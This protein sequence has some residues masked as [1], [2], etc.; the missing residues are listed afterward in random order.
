MKFN[1]E[2][3]SE[4]FN[5]IKNIFLK[6]PK[7][8]IFILFVIVFGLIYFNNNSNTVKV[9]YLETG[10]LK[11]IVS[12]SGI[13]TPSQES[14]LAFE[15]SGRIQSI[16][17]KV[18]DSVKTGQ[19]LSNLSSGV[20]YA[21]V[22]NAQAQLGSAQANLQDALNGPSLT[23]I[24]VKQSTV[25]S[26]LITLYSDYNSSLDTI[27]I[28]NSSLT[29][30]LGNKIS[31]IFTYSSSYKLNFNSCDQSLQSKIEND[32]MSLDKK[33]SDLYDLSNSNLMFSSLNS[34]EENKKKIDEISAQVYGSIL[35][36]SANLDDINRL[37]NLP[38]GISDTTLDKYRTSL[39]SA[40]TSISTLISNISS[41]KSKIE[42][43]RSIL[44]SAKI[45]LDQ[46]KAGSTSERIKSLKA[47]VDQ[48]NANLISAKAANSKNSLVAPFDGIVTAVNINPGEI[49]SPNI[50][51]ISLISSNSL[52]LKIKLAEVDLVKVKVG[53]KAI[54]RLDTYGDSVIFDGVVGQV[55]PASTKE[56]NVSAYFAKIIFLNQDERIRS[57]MNG[58]SDI[59][60]QEK[61]GVNYVY[62]NYLKIDSTL[63]RVKV[64]KDIKK[65]NKI[66][67]DDNDSNIEW[68]NVEIGMRDS[69]GKIE[70]ISGL[71]K[72]DILYPIG[73]E[74]FSSSTKQ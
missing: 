38:C 71:S 40:K 11:E 27:R 61:Q 18:G 60:T 56:G 25:D 62:P 70:I 49:S 42:S 39:S 20:E 44:S 43:D 24:A 54:V 53:N 6:N 13:V 46:I 22:L 2:S 4:I 17:V 23:D 45:S 10:D 74:I 14:S 1:K 19:V 35:A 12:V 9:G 37:L 57:G 41:I 47:M 34:E 5:T 64:I 69:F 36:V 50:P 32:R 15:K 73:T 31:N 67:Q 29:D 48:A 3:F 8:I 30:I 72:N 33:I 51:A 21:G 58:S 59:V 68:R 66:S 28:I 26:A 63:S 65:V 7:K 16:N 52:E 55:D